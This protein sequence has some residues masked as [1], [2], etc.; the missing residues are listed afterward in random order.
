MVTGL[1][2]VDA[3]GRRGDRGARLGI[4]MDGARPVAA[5]PDDERGLFAAEFDDDPL[6]VNKKR[7]RRLI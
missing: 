7:D 3:G 1:I 2:A 6:R 5:L 4:V